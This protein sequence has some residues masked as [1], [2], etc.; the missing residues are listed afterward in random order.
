MGSASLIASRHTASPALS[1]HLRL[2]S[3]VTPKTNL[4]PIPFIPFR[5]HTHSILA[6]LVPVECLGRGAQARV[7]R[8]AEKTIGRYF[9]MKGM[10]H[11]LSSSS[12]F[13]QTIRFR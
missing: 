6:T 9:A 8:V 7:L 13:E 3:C 12:M 1:S 5:T 10:D 4:G 2:F 11:G